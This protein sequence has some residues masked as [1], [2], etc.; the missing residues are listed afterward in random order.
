M[1]LTPLE[2]GADVYEGVS[3][4]QTLVERVIDG[5]AKLGA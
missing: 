3:L 1:V 5:Q 2:P 4:L